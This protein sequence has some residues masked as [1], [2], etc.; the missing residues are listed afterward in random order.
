M[1]RNYVYAFKS[2]NNTC[3]VINYSGDSHVNTFLWRF[4]VWNSGGQAKLHNDDPHSFIERWYEC[5]L[6]FFD[7][8][9]T[10]TMKRAFERM[11]V[12]LVFDYPFME[13]FKNV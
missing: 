7:M 6:E 2:V 9:H 12:K 11:G 4:D 3:F 5:N 1:N 8:L 10:E 13:E